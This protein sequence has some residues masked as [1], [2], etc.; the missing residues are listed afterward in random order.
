MRIRLVRLGDLC[1]LARVFRVKETK[2]SSLGFEMSFK[3]EWN[4]VH[5]PLCQWHG[6]YFVFL[7]EYDE[8]CKKD[9]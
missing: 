3:A 2:G 8:F 6:A 7:E 9:I 1:V 5:T 4:R